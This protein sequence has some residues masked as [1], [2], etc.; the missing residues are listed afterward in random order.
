MWMCL[1][2]AM[3]A[4]VWV[5]VSRL[6]PAWPHSWQVFSTAQYQL[7]VPSSLLR[8]AKTKPA[9]LFAQHAQEPSKPYPASVTTVTRK[10]THVKRRSIP[11]PLEELP[12]Q[13]EAQ[14]I[15]PLQYFPS[16]GG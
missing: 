9:F 7:Q 3:G 5:R 13:E 4:C 8:N 10:G 2:W 12:N 1:V 11:N 14:M 16:C 6:P 15:V